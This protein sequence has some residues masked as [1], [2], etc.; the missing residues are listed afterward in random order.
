[1]HLTYLY[2][3]YLGLT[4]DP[5]LEWGHQDGGALECIVHSCNLQHLELSCT[6]S[7]PVEIQNIFFKQ[8]NALENKV[9]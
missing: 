5:P 1:M 6:P 4:S 3:C 9:A 7:S 2:V 8:M